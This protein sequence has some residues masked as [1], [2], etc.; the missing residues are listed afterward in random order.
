MKLNFFNRASPYYPFRWYVVFLLAL[1]ALMAFHD[2][3]GRRM[4]SFS[5]DEWNAGGPGNHYHK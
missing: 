1:T 3:T 4:L 5:R 2:L